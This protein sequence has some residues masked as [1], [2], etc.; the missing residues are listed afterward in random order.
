MN[1]IPR[2]LLPLLLAL[3]TCSLMAQPTNC[4]TFDEPE[5]GTI[6]DESNTDPGAVIYQYEGSNLIMNTFTDQ[7][8]QN[9]FDQISV[10]AEGLG[11][12]EPPALF[13]NY[14]NATFEYTSPVNTLCFTGFLS[15]H[16]INFG[17]NGEVGVFESLLD[18]NIQQEWPNY[19]IT[20]SSSGNEPGSPVSVCI[21]GPLET[22]TIGGIEFLLDDVCTDLFTTCSFNDPNLQAFCSSVGSPY[23]SVDFGSIIGGNDFVDVFVDGVF[24]DFYPIDALPIIVDG[25][26][27]PAGQEGV[28]ITVCINDNPDCCYTE[29]VL[30]PNCTDTECIT[31]DEPEVGTTYSTDTGVEPGDIVY[32]YPNANMIMGT[33]ASAN[34]EINFDQIQVVEGWVDNLDAPSLY[35][36]YAT[37]TFGYHTPVQTL[38]FTG[39]LSGHDINFGLNGNVQL[40]TSLVDPALIEAFPDFDITVAPIEPNSSG[41]VSVCISGLIE[42]FTIGG[43]E[44]LLDDLCAS[45]PICDISNLQVGQY[46]CNPDVEP[47]IFYLNFDHNQSAAESFQLFVNGDLY[48][49][50]TYGDL[51]ILEIPIA[52]NVAQFLVVDLNDDSCAEDL[53]VEVQNCENACNGFAATTADVYCIEAQ[54]FGAQVVLST[55]PTG[56]I[57]RVFGLSNNQLIDIAT[58][59]SFAGLNLIIDGDGD[60]EGYRLVDELTGCETTLPPFDF[61][62]AACSECEVFITAI[63]PTDCNPNGVYSVYLDIETTA[64]WLQYTVMVGEDQ[65]YGP[66]NAEEFP[67]TVGS[68]I[69]TPGVVTTVVVS[70]PNN[71]C[72]VWDNV[73]QDCTNPCDNFSATLNG[74]ECLSP[75]NILVSF[76]L[77]GVEPG[78]PIRITNANGGFIEELIF[79]E[80]PVLVDF[81]PIAGSNVLLIEAQEL[82]CETILD[83]P[84]PPDC[85]P[86]CGEY[87]IYNVFC[88]GQTNQ[89]A[90]IGFI[91]IGPEGEVFTVQVGNEIYEFTYG[92]VE[93]ELV[94]N[95]SNT[96]IFELLFSQPGSNCFTSLSVENPCHNPCEDRFDIVEIYCSNGAVAIQFFAEGPA[97]QL[98]FVAVDDQIFTFEYGQN[99]Y[100][101][102]VVVDPNI[103]SFQYVFFDEVD[104]C[105]VPIWVDNPCLN[106]CENFF[107][108]LVEVEC[109]FGDSLLIT[110]A[111]DGIEAGEP[112]RF[113]TN[114][115]PNFVAE[116]TF[117]SN[118]VQVLVPLSSIGSFVLYIE[119]QGINCEAGF[120]IVT[121]DDCVPD[122]GEYDITNVFCEDPS[123]PLTF[124]EFVAFGPEG[125]V[126]T[127]QVNDETF[128][129]TFGN[130]QYQLVIDNATSQVYEVIF[131]QPGTNCF[132][133]A[134]FQNPC[135]NSCEERF[136]IVENFCNDGFAFVTFIAEG[137]AGELF[138]VAVGDEVFTFEYGQ[139]TYEL[140]MPANPNIAAY[141]YVF[142]D[143]V[144]G[145]EVGIW[146]DNPCLNTCENFVVEAVQV[147]CEG[148]DSLNVILIFDGIEPGEPLR[149]TTNHLPNFV[150]E[151]TYNNE[152]VQISIPVA[153]VEVFTL[154]VQA[155]GINCDYSLNIEVPEDCSGNC[156]DFGAEIISA[157]CLDTPF[158]GLEIRLFGVEADGRNIIIQ[159]I[160][161][162][163]LYTVALEENP[164]FLPWPVNDDGVLRITDLS[165]GCSTEID[166]ETPPDCVPECGEQFDVVEVYCSDDGV[167]VFLFTADGPEGL[168][169]F[170]QVAG[171]E[172][173]F[174]YGESLYDLAL[175]NI[176]PNTFTYELRFFDQQTG[177]VEEILVDNPCFCFIEILAVETTECDANGN[178]FVEMDIS[179][180]TSWGNGI[181]IVEAEGYT[182]TIEE[183]SSSVTIGPF[184]GGP[185]EITITEAFTGACT[186][187][188]TV[189]QDCEPI[190]ETYDLVIEG[191]ECDANGNYFLD[192]T[193]ESN[194]NGPFVVF[195]ESTGES[196][197][198]TV[199][200][201][202]VQ[203]GPYNIQEIQTSLIIVFLEETNGCTIEDF[204]VQDCEPICPTIEVFAEPTPCDDNGQYS[205]V[206]GIGTNVSGL[207][208]VTHLNTGDVV[209]NV[210]NS[211]FP[212]TFGPYDAEEVPFGEFEILFEDG[213]VACE[214]F[215]D[216]VT[217]CPP[218]GECG[219][220]NIFAEA[221]ECVDGE[222]MVDVEFDNP[223]GGPLGF[224]IFGDGMIFGPYQYGETFYTFGPLDGSEEEHDILLLDIANPACFGD[225]TLDY[226]CSDECNIT[227]VIAEITEC[228]GEVFGVELDVVG[229]NL[230]DQFIV[231][232]NGNNYGTFSYADLPIFLGPFEGDNETVYEF[233]VIDLLNPTCTNFTEVGPVNCQPCEIRDLTYEVDCG[234][235][236]Y[237]VT[238]NFIY[239]NPESDGFRLFIGNDEV[240]TF[241]YD[242]QPWTVDLPYSVEGSTIRV[243]DFSYELCG[244][245]IDFEIPCCSLG[246]ILNEFGVTDCED[247]GEY[248][249][250]VNNF[251]GGNLG[252]SLVIT[253]APA[254]SSIIATEVVS[255]GSLPV[256]IGPLSGDGTTAYIVVLAD[257]DNSCAV[258]TTVEPVYCDNNACVEFEGV[259]GVFG[260]LL[261]HPDG[262]VV[263]EENQV[264]ISYEEN[265][266]TECNSCFLFITDGIPGVDFGEGQIVATENSG[267]GLNFE[268][269]SNSFNTVNVEF[270]YPGGGFTA[271]VNGADPVTADNISDLPTVIAPGVELQVS[272]DANDQT[273]GV[274]TFSGDN[275]E[276][277]NLYSNESAGFDNVC[278]SLDDNVWPGDTNSDNVAN[279]IDLLSIGLTYGFSGPA[280]INM[281]TEWTG[282]ISQNWAG[283]FANGLNHKH[284]DAN[285]DGVI[286]ELDEEVLQ[287]NYGLL[288]GPIGAF[289]ELPY[290][291]LDPP[292]FVDLEGADQLPAGTNVQ[293]PVVAGAADQMIDDIYGLAF[294][295][296]IDPELFD[297]SSLEVIYPTS[298]F[299]EPGINTTH[300]HRVYPDGRIEVALSRTDHNNVSGFGPIM[301]FRIII[302]DIAGVHEIPTTLVVDNI[303]AIDHDEQRLTIRPG[304]SEVLLTETK[305]G[306]DRDELI[307][308]FGIFPNPTLDVVYFKNAYNLP[309][310]RLDLFNA[311]GQQLASIKGPGMQF[312]LSG[313]PAG[314]YMLQIHLEG[315]IFTERVVKLE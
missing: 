98:F 314:V 241:P 39:Y 254:G 97:G 233:G 104:G 178:Y 10:T 130:E 190:C 167:P 142:Y 7:Q 66:F 46:A 122:C 287:Q 52:T 56:Q 288:H 277:I 21:F 235:D 170:V 45:D 144:T 237:A 306:M 280:R 260:P 110:L 14:A 94:I 219:F 48:E 281:N 270:Y 267:V 165:T 55:P 214:Y 315:Q 126:F 37:A 38:C 108:E 303:L 127:V 243:E 234:E 159:N 152:P 236:F 226:V 298:W 164:F 137:P 29:T 100:E 169:F 173:A 106:S 210:P 73:S 113:T 5:V 80:N 147:S 68:I 57:F 225:Y 83:Y 224:Y 87:D 2:N 112:L 123:S 91:A 309:P 125:E 15:G 312:D 156:E 252:D 246:N 291:D 107:A 228:D 193:F 18:P 139:S 148:P 36:N 121:P 17:I 109:F 84:I 221:Y 4:I 296:Q 282:L 131:S 95:N 120:D 179:A 11:N 264:A 286:D 308:T 192:V 268:A 197:V 198:T 74:V 172:Y 171:E 249:F 90:V 206:V 24:Y 289:E 230:G 218:N 265:P 238:V 27:P 311:A 305:E 67:M 146:V 143:E 211:Q 248:F 220:N 151:R 47:H 258:T 136:D 182:V 217:D 155:Q 26:T 297:M 269:V 203:F 128:Q 304:V 284:A 262:E 34:G 111:F 222:F 247:D 19:D 145:C 263:A 244:E 8:N 149:I 88:D 43:I 69:G 176:I 240:A 33:F 239:E 188:V 278:L 256:E 253:Y 124:I 185:V 117:T 181:F 77:N 70:G 49:T 187:Q 82:G 295:V 32:Q 279:S 245:T 250:V 202:P 195:N 101:L 290:T 162:G 28:T 199:E 205:V 35:I 50:F 223:A 44:F 200:D 272:F 157:T 292:V 293:I 259:E 81:T 51:P 96:A 3:L 302:D 177:C 134:S 93:Y 313:Y 307:S 209:E 41:L 86:Q 180:G 299:G 175:N 161:T 189:D 79:E 72:V 301:Y 201:L 216:Y 102:T 30:L 274:L 92:N 40:F 65:V 276:Q 207:F 60:P 261:G 273:K 119:A 154:S 212:I 59:N 208:T 99:I 232:G 12:N 61:D 242:G 103:A 174:T 114:H 13:V 116:Q 186:E 191:T 132:T 1:N 85:P 310:N 118:P 229:S 6:F 255:Y 251:E 115:L 257:Q 63:E 183:G 129:Y 105:E 158:V 231:V 75:N 9:W 71:A 275:I 141:Q 135:Y 227:E 196:I 62:P 266:V 54:T 140:G 168:P 166:Y 16:E 271:A 20:I 215:A 76:H 64:P 58:Y 23:V 204:Y 133:T 283:D 89:V 153:G 150:V 53:T 160:E 213:V 25:I 294:T 285:G 22:F 163:V 194:V 42:T 78:E 138:Y 300:I 184:D 31:F